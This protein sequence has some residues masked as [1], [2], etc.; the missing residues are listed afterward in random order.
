MTFETLAR[1]LCTR[2]HAEGRD[3]LLEPELYD[4][5]RA[6]GVETPTFFTVD[7]R[8]DVAAQLKPLPGPKAVVKVVS[9]RIT[10]KTEAGGVR[11]VANDPKAIAEAV[12]AMMAT[13]RERC[14]AEIADTVRS[15][16]VSEFV[17]G[18]DALGGQLF[19]GMRH[20]PDM[21]PVMAIGFGGLDA[22]EL[23]VKFGPGQ[24][25]VLF[26]PA[27]STPEQA[28]AKFS[29]SF[30]YRK[31][32]GKTREAKKLCDD[33][34]LLGVLR[35]FDRLANQV[36]NTADFGFVVTDFEVNP[37]FVTGGRVVAV[38]AFLRFQP[39]LQPLRSTLLEQVDLLLKPQT[40][41]IMGASNKGVNPGR[42]IL[43]NLLREQFPIENIR[44]IHPEGDEID[45]VRCCP[46]ITDLPWPADLLVVAVG[47]K[48]VA[49]I[50]D[51][52]MKTGKARSVVL[53][54]GGMD[55]T[56]DGKET[57]QQIKDAFFGARAA[58][59][60]TPVIVGPNCLGIRS[61]PGRYDT[62]FI[63]S[64]KLPLPEGDVS[65]L[66]IVSQSGAYLITRMDDL[67]A[68]KPRYAISTGN[69]MDLSQVDFVEALLRD[70]AVEVMGLYIEGFN[71]MDGLR[72]AHL[73]RKGRR[74]GRDFVVYKAGRTAEGLGATA[75]HTASISGDYASCAEVLADAGALV[76]G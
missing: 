65:N 74:M 18:T 53:I 49:G 24:S 25:T 56:D 73:V 2:A 1:D 47:A 31:V 41:A 72:L 44:A 68:L 59:R 38:D 63:P 67:P 69:Q 21:G 14:G 62:L 60:F 10:H 13:V 71:P 5:L 55:E 57:A 6:G 35:F 51:E 22:E 20:S 8:G 4:L 33:A 70:D 16:L 29:K 28:L 7:P 43:R 34:A 75:S 45:G 66:A 19:A 32:T 26:S 37:F 11:I 54:P 36:S 42:V 27:M 58:G 52:V 30:A 3:T 15:V 50:L 61:C 9:P 76:A 23:A 40:A 39:G 17:A 46:S 12:P 64:Y 48:S